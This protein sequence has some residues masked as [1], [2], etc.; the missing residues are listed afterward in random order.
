MTGQ[1][2]TMLGKSRATPEQPV[3]TEQLEQ[4]ELLVTLVLQEVLDYLVQLA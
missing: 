3:H 1:Y 4:P 2:G